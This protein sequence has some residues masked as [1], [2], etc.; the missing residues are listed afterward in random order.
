[1]VLTY[2]K[3][4][5]EARED[6]IITWYHHWLKLGFDALETQLKK[7]RRTE[8]DKFC[9]NQQVTLADICLIP[10]VYNAKRYHFCLDEYPAIERIYEHCMTLAAFEQTKP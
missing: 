1:K 7:Y 2:L 5:F 8:S 3:K 9:V 6:E 10:Q 4:N